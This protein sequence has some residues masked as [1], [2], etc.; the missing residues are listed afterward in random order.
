MVRCN[1]EAQI[2]CHTLK[3][4]FPASPE[5]LKFSCTK[6][7]LLILFGKGSAVCCE[8]HFFFGATAQLGRT[9]RHC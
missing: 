7:N 6:T 1:T 3:Y 8:N 5:I 4:A 9:P 2:S